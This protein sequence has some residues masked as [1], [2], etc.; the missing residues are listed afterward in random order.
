VPAR[1]RA[2]PFERSPVGFGVP[3]GLPTG[4]SGSI[5]GVKLSIS[6]PDEL[7]ARMDGARGD[8]SRSMWIRRAVEV[9]AVPVSGVIEGAFAEP[10]APKV[11]RSPSP[12]D[13]IDA[14]SHALVREQAKGAEAT[15]VRVEAGSML[16]RSERVA[17]A[18]GVVAQ[19]RPI[20]QKRK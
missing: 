11:D 7:V 12:T 16:P 13:G 2:L 17:R 6:L 4:R 10:P 3:R 20:V 14:A 15:E 8:V 5:G 9:R 1:V 18:R 19:P